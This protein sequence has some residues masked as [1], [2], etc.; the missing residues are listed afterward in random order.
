M[1]LK[2]SSDGYFF[3]LFSSFF[4]SNLTEKFIC[5]QFNRFTFYLTQPTFALHL[6]L[7]LDRCDRFDTIFEFDNK[8]SRTLMFSLL[9]SS[10]FLS[11]FYF[12]N[13]SLVISIFWA[14]ASSLTLLTTSQT[15][16]LLQIY[17]FALW[18]FHQ[19]NSIDENWWCLYTCINIYI[20]SIW[21]NSFR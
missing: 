21:L 4:R 11:Y 17:I 7:C 12:P 19:V 2:Q 16:V 10:F 18:T 1:K 8:R 15:D 13:K 3:F 20:N 5:Q 14:I 9:F 6:I